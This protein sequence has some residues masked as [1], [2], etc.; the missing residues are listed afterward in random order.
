[1][2]PHGLCELVDLQR[3]I[4]VEPS[5]D[6]SDPI[7]RIALGPDIR[8]FH[9]TP[10]R[11][12]KSFFARLC[13]AKTHKVSNLRACASVQPSRHRHIRH[14]SKPRRIELDLDLLETERADDIAMR[15]ARLKENRRG[16][17]DEVFAELG[18]VGTAAEDDKRE[19][20]PIM[21]MLRNARMTPVDNSS[22]P[23][24]AE[25]SQ[26]LSIREGPPF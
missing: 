26:T 24:S 10:H 3:Y 25:I 7:G 5:R 16:A 11:R 20:R 19:Q 4:R 12:A 6:R 17:G 14:G 22:D 9:E 8:T 18:L 21:R 1:M 15:S 13:A 23:G 2:P